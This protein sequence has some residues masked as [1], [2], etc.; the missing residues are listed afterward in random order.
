[1]LAALK[2]IYCDKEY[3]KRIFGILEKHINS[4]KKNTGRKGLDLWCIFILSQVRLCLDISYDGLHNLTNNHRSM[5]HLMEVEKNFCYERVEF[6][7]QNICGN[8]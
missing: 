2:A 3:N 4:G 5:R 1:L 8:V 7:Y 6:E